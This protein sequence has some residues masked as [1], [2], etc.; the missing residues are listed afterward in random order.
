MS[1]ALASLRAATAECVFQGAGFSPGDTA[2]GLHAADEL[3]A[4]FLALVP[5]QGGGAPRRRGG[6]AG[7][8]RRAVAAG[9]APLTLLQLPAEILVLVLC[10]SAHHV[11]PGPRR[12]HMLGTLPRQAAADV[13]RGGGAAAARRASRRAAACVLTACPQ[14]FSSWPAHVAVLKRRHAEALPPVAAGGT[15]RFF[16]MAEGER[17][18]SCGAEEAKAPGALGQER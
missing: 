12:C 8:A 6:S 17:L 18:L 2:T 9:Q 3:H 7:A 5:T 15:G 14:D 4:L 11:Q 1:S 13:S 16:F 10:R